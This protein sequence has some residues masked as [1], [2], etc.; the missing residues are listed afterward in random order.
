MM[1]IKVEKPL[2]EDS[3]EDHRQYKS[4]TGFKKTS[5][6]NRGSISARSQSHKSSPFRFEYG[7]GYREQDNYTKAISNLDQTVFSM[8]S[9]MD[10]HENTM[11]D[12]LKR[13]LVAGHSQL[14]A[15]HFLRQLYDDRQGLGPL[16]ENSERFQ[17]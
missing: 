15:Q 1:F 9:R 11:M 4:K 14:N 8:K 16:A 7:H 17:K 13:G 12:N 10:L 3:E 5:E 2:D 6:L